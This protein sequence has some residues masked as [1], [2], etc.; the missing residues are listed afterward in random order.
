M[1]GPWWKCSYLSRGPE[2]SFLGD[3]AQQDFENLSYLSRQAKTRLKPQAQK[4]YKFLEP[5][6]FGVSSE[7]NGF[8]YP[9]AY[10]NQRTIT[11][12]INDFIFEFKKGK[13]DRINWPSYL[14]N[15]SIVTDI[16]AEETFITAIK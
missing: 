13:D 9:L 12:E 1:R 3:E 15:K 2:G 14:D 11:T 16:Y 5:I 10:L 7:V 8:K 6:A 4:K